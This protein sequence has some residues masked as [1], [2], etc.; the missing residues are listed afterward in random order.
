MPPK[1][2]FISGLPRSGSTLLS[3]LLRQN[4]RFHAAMSSP[5]AAIFKALQGAMSNSN[6]YAMFLNEGQRRAILTACVEAYLA[7]LK[8]GRAEVVFDTNRLW[9]TKLPA[10][11]ALFPEARMIC[12]V[13]NLAWVVDSLERLVR[14]N[15]LQ[16]SGIFTYD[17]G[18]TVYSRA[19]GLMSPT[20]MVGFALHGLR[21]ALF[22]EQAD[23]VLLVRYESLAADPLGTLNGIYAFLG[24]PP[25]PHDPERVESLPGAAEFDARLGTP[26]LHSV[27][28]AVRAVER[29]SVLPTDLFTRYRTYT[30]WENEGEMPPGIRM[31]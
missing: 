6:E 20:G 26:G 21:E 4:P 19:E 3:A 24:E 5:L 14:R 12:C 18:G 8:P 31:V 28:T 29:R 11:A 22:G 10:L 7:G 16:P 23:R 30:F 17:S 9:T 2:H 13:R 1:L 25:Y 15:A 27:G